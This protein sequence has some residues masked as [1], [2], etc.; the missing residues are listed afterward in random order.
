MTQSLYFWLI[1]CFPQLGMV[2][3][4]RDVTR[5]PQKTFVFFRGNQNVYKMFSYWVEI[6]MFQFSEISISMSKSVPWFWFRFWSFPSD[7]IL[8]LFNKKIL[9][10]DFPT[11]WFQCQNCKFDFGFDVI[12]SLILVSMWES[13][14]RIRHCKFDS[15][16]GILILAWELGFRHRILD[17]CIGI[18]ILASEFRFRYQISISM[19]KCQSTVN[20]ICHQTSLFRLLIGI[21][22]PTLEIEIEIPITFHNFDQ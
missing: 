9:C 5:V 22:I 6:S 10:F 19:S 12:V 14:F 15:G 1:E 16:K 2:S 3:G 11:F 4:G 17:S 8:F 18:W 13:E 20:E 21:S 7:E